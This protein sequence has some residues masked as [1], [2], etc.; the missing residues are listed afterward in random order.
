MTKDM[1]REGKTIRLLYIGFAAAV[2]LA[3][4]PLG[5]AQLL[6][7]CLLLV[8]CIGAYYYRWKSAGGSLMENHMTYQI[9]TLWI[10]SALFAIGFIVATLWFFTAGDHSLILQITANAQSGIAPGPADIEPIM[11][12][13]LAVNGRLL[14]LIGAACFLPTFLYFGYRL[15]AGYRRAR[16]GERLPHPGRWF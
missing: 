16:A 8:L 11:H 5:A 2:L 3:L 7:L 10:G 14:L 13:Y 4:V 1:T 12:D 15:I 9:V 6:S